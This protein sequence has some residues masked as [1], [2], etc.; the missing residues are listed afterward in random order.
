MLKRLL[1]GLAVALVW[2]GG[3]AP[4]L[5]SSGG[6]L[7]N[8]RTQFINAS[9]APLASGYVNIYLPNTTT[10][11]TTYQDPALTIANTNPIILDSNGMASIWVAPGNYREQVYDANSVLLFDQT[12]SSTNQTSALNPGATITLGTDLSCTPTLFTG[13]SNIS[14]P[15][16]VVAASTATAGK[17]QLTTNAVAQAGASTSQAVTPAALAS[18]LQPDTMNEV[19]DSSVTPNTITLTLVPAPSSYTTGMRIRFQAANTSTA[20]VTINVNGLGAKSLFAGSGAIAVGII[21]GN[22]Y[23]ITYDGTH[24]Q[25]M[26]VATGV[27]NSVQFAIHP[28][29][30]I[31]QWGHFATGAYA[32]GTQSVSFAITFPSACLYANAE[33]DNNAA[34]ASPNYA[35]QVVSSCS[36]SSV[37]FSAA[38]FQS[39]GKANINGFY[40]HVAGN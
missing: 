39:G 22:F 19:L 8:G 17:S 28:G 2:L 20:A 6:Q 27:V 13:A 9:G 40:W 14:I 1:V 4:S 29:G 18:V 38:G 16:S 21:A 24:F 12:T 11:V 37:S 3:V 32:G 7:I 35:M 26:S 5:A 36:T 15:C 33:S 34:A 23:D 10:P 25:L 30:L 31:E